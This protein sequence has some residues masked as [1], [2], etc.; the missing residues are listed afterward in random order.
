MR[1][2]NKIGRSLYFIGIFFSAFGL[3]LILIEDT[4]K[5]LSVIGMPLII[6]G[7]T[8]LIASNFFRKNNDAY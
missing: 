7:V 8:I 2:H 4:P 6:I 5:S 1:K 3:A